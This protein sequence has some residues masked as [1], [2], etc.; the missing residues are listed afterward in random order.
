MATLN[1][2]REDADVA[3]DMALT[4][5]FT[6]PCHGTYQQDRSPMKHSAAVLAKL[7]GSFT[8][9]IGADVSHKYAAAAFAVIGL[10]G[11]ESSHPPGSAI[12]KM[13]F[14][15]AFPTVTVR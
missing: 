2:S 12:C 14:E 8:G 11:R 5:Y 1:V 6:G 10:L 13:V 7:N 9:I 4:W 3:R 15:L